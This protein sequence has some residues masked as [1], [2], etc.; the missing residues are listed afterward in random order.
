MEDPFDV[1]NPLVWG[2]HAIGVWCEK[3]F[4]PATPAVTVA[5]A[6]QEMAELIKAVAGDQ[7]A[8]VILEEIADVII[9][10]RRLA[11]QM[12]G[13]WYLGS[14]DHVNRKMQINV[15]RKWK[16]NGDGTAQHE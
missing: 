6:N 14:E 10:L 3:T 11:Y 7:P 9:C 12:G 13:S 1:P 4:G 2:D 15:K 8:Q 5:R 16:L